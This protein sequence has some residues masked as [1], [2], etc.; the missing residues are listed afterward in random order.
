MNPSSGLQTALNEIR[1][2]LI[3]NN[4]LYQEQIPLVNEYTSSQ[5]YGQSLL[6]LPSDLRNKFIPP[7]ANAS[8]AIF[9]EP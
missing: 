5:V 3:D 7:D 6:N 4:T 9:R 2:T 8:G 1:N